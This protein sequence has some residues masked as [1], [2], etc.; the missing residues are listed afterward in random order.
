V[1][2]APGTAAVA[3]PGVGG[4]PRAARA[5]AV[6]AGLLA[7]A[8]L[9][10]LRA[11]GLNVEDEGTLLYQIARFA[12]GELPYVDFQTGYTPG[13][14]VLG[15]ALW[16]IAGDVPALRVLLAL[17]HA[18]TVAGLAHLATRLARPSL[19]LGAALLYLAFIPVHPGEFCA[20]NVPYPAWL[21]TLGWVGTAAAALAF[22]ERRRRGWLVLAG[23]AAAATF[24]VK[25][26]A[27]VFA[28]AA[29]TAA[30]LGV[31]PAAGS[32]RR[33]GALSAGLWVALWVATVA[34]AWLTLRLR[35]HPADLLVHFVPIAAA[36]AAIARPPAVRRPGLAGDAGALLLPFVA[37]SA[38]WLGDF[39]RR[40]GPEAFAREVLLLGS[41]AAELFYV[42]YPRLE[43]W[44]ALVVALAA[45]FAA[46]G[47]L[48]ARRRVSPARAAWGCLIGAGALAGAAL[49]AGL[50][51]EG[52]VWSVIWQLQSAA[53]AL[54]LATH[55]AGVVWL[56]RAPGPRPPVRTR[57]F[58]GV[59]MHLQLYP[60]ADF[61]H[62]LFAAPLT[63]V[64]AVH[65]LDRALRWWE[66]GAAA[67]GAPRAGRLV[68]GGATAL[69]A[70]AA[71]LA[72]APGLGALAAG[73]RFVLPFD[74]A[75][76]G[77]ERGRAGDLRDLAAASASLASALR[78]GD[79][80]VAFPAASV[81]LLLAGGRNPGRYDYFFPG[82]PDHFE[83]AEYLDALAADPPAGILSLR[84][85]F[86][87]FDGAPA[88]YFLLGRHV[89]DRYAPV[90]RHGRFDVLAP[91]STAAVE[92]TAVPQPHDGAL[93]VPAASDLEARLAAVAALADHPPAAVAGPLLDAA[94]GDD[95]VVRTVALGTLLDAI[96]REPEAGL[97]TWVEARALD[98]R[99]QILLLRTVRDLRDPRAASYLFRV[100]AGGDPR[101][102]RD[103]LGAMHVTRAELV[104]RRHLWAGP[105][106][107][108]GWPARP[109]LLAAVRA[110]LADPAADRR[111]VAFAA[112]LAGALGDRASVEPL[113][114]LLHGG[115]P[116]SAT[117]GGLSG[118]TSAETVA[119]AA[120][121]LAELAPEALACQLAALLARREAAILEL[122][123][124]TLLRLAES[125]DPVRTE[126]R[127]CLTAAVR[128]P[129]P[130]RADAVWIAAALGD[131]AFAPALRAAL[132]GAAPAVRRAAA[133]ALGE[134]PAEVAT[135][136]A[137]ARAAAT[138]PD[139]TVRRVAARAAAKQVGEAPR[140]LHGVVW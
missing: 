23:L 127:R 43:P 122:V 44:G 59:M 22:V 61:P 135:G 84:R 6:A 50:R 25:P 2:P 132:A 119:S 41:G 87:W 9:L 116:A 17:V 29:A 120:S 69:I 60:R 49:G 133:W 3:G 53:F 15:A 83:E 7:L 104:A 12:R 115:A 114:R 52:L 24:A 95:P 80:S 117:G 139:P 48:V 19:G 36:M 11:Y 74:A 94:T 72:A 30:V 111:A 131:P 136:A 118:G 130:G 88:Y 31:G 66:S 54:V 103:A 38:L 98:R 107:P 57:V 62:L 26:N 79:S 5:S 112:H 125:G 90:A 110:T 140:A 134:L 21:A 18:L 39:L 56:W 45:G 109:S 137:L 97:E 121:A 126:A 33:A 82:R 86:T 42:P 16:R 106:D 8:Y 13:F 28:A 14:F 40:L 71:G 65:L 73:P 138:D 75:P 55:A 124:A 68:A 35:P 81:A 100:V 64:L 27:G 20:F 78:G 99:A 91:R 105:D 32:R 1:G 70:A 4:R 51:P 10:P 128:G 108:V 58:F 123:P 102:T 67:C 34:G 92:P 76:V 77:V 89:R 46:A 37:I 63:L 47:A 101:L 85:R 93:A 129:G 113:R 96:A